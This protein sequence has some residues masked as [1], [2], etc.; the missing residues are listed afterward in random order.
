MNERRGP[1]RAPSGLSRR[2]LLSAAVLGGAA[3][4]VAACAD[5]LVGGSS[6]PNGA[7]LLIGVNLEL[8]GLNGPIGRDQLNGVNIAIDSINQDGFVVAGRRR[9]VRLVAKPF[10]NKSNWPTAVSGMKALTRM[11]GIAAVVGA[12][13][14]PTSNRMAA[15]ADASAI[16]MVSTASPGGQDMLLTRELYTFVLGPRSSQVAVLLAKAIAATAPGAR[17][18]AVI[19]TSDD[20]GLDGFTAMG[21]AMPPSTGV[22]LTE[23]LAPANGSRVSAFVPVAR[24]AVAAKPDA[25]VVWSLSPLSGYIAQALSD[26]GYRGK[27]FF[28]SGAGSD[29]TISG[30]NHQAVQGAYLV[31]P[32]LLGGPPLA[33]TDPAT[34]LRRNFYQS[35]IVDN[36]IF[37]G[38]APAGADA[39]WLIVQAAISADSLAPS[40][41]R[42]ALETLHF[43]G[44][45][46]NYVFAANDHGGL[47][48]ESLSLFTIRQAGWAPADI[49]PQA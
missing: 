1:V 15:I 18:V 47:T 32:S 28:D 7:D 22:T 29:E 40:D 48:G 20:Y 36:K 5:P 17:N 2:S 14:G 44:I 8:S 21:N 27:L 39:V 9:R 30:N 34:L 33:V 12:S 13:T 35:Y 31:A 46:G 38:L 23:M 41:I 37:S 43:D 25:I 45:A 6:T 19:R 11:P 16:P 4:A 24:Q 49:G 42:A 26:S 10:D 3:A